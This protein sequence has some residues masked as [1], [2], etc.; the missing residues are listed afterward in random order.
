MFGISIVG[1][2][3]GESHPFYGKLRGEAQSFVNFKKGIKYFPQNLFPFSPQPPPEIKNDNSLR[4]HFLGKRK[5]WI[6]FFSETGRSS[7]HVESILSIPYRDRVAHCFKLAIAECAVLA[8][9]THQATEVPIQWQSV[10]F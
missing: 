2:G 7:K 3:G 9:Q 4:S 1:W 10:S 6:L 5:N 8:E